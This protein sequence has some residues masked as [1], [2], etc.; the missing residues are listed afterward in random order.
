[1]IIVG[2]GSA[3]CVLAN[4]L[5]ADPTRRVLL[6]EAGG[7]GHSLTTRIPAAFPR[8]FKTP[9]DWAL[10]TEP[11]PGLNDRLLYWPRGRMLGGSSAMNAM[12]WMRG[13]AEDYDAWEAA[14]NPGWG[15]RDVLPAFRRA[16]D[17]RAATGEHVGHDG[18]MRIDHQREPSPLTR[19]W[20]EA[21]MESGFPIRDDLNHGSSE[22]VGLLH[23]SQRGGKR[24]STATAYLRPARLRPNLTVTT[25][26]QV[27]RIA[28]DGSRAAGVEVRHATGAIEWIAAGHVVLC[29][30]AVHSP[31]LLMCSGIGPGS[32]LRDAG[33]AVR[34]DLPGV[35]QNL[36]DH[37]VA[38]IG[39]RCREP[40]SLLAAERPWRL[41][42]WLL[43]RSGPLTSPVAEGAG[44]LRSDPSVDRPDLELIFAPTF[45]VDHGFSNPPGHGYTL[46]AVLLRPESRGS[47]SLRSADPLAAPVIRPGY[48]TDAADLPRLV[49]GLRSCRQIAAASAF[50]RWRG[51]EALPGEGACTAEQLAEHVR[52]T[53]QTLYH[54]VGTCAMGTGLHAVVSPKLEV[55]GVE[56]LSVVDASIMPTIISGHT[57]APTIMIAERAAE[58]MV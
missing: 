43:T 56:R 54:P 3:G 41:L 1:V 49:A 45:F 46:G 37:L 7:E 21:A 27:L 44:Y 17:H 11:E 6:L 39:V 20:L 8:L 34:V 52:N 16:E 47:T 12:L 2:A 31:H 9:A 48:L 25:G 33:V 35:G 14:G 19:S 42:Q 58:M 40:A 30:G 38:G 50:G 10:E 26:V 53:A 15:W 24:E 51:A 4:R 57:N 18:P 36:Q 28:F 22:G 32:S 55:H 13:H 23:V 29:A 5:S